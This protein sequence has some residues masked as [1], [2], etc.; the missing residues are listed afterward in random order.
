MLLR[1]RLSF[2]VHFLSRR[3]DLRIFRQ[4]TFHEIIS[5]LELTNS[6]IWA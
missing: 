4:A 2:S 3:H 1:I 5:S 6:R